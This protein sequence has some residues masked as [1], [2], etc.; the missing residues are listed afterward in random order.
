MAMCNCSLWHCTG[1]YAGPNVTAAG[2]CFRACAVSAAAAAL[3]KAHAEVTRLQEWQDVFK[4]M[5]DDKAQQVRQRVVE[6]ASSWNPQPAD[7]VGMPPCPHWLCT[8]SVAEP[9][10][11][12]RV[13]LGLQAAQELQAF[14]ARAAERQVA[15][16][17]RPAGSSIGGAACQCTAREPGGL[18]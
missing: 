18:M 6:R 8:R 15:A 17:G 12:L 5:A 2:P 9:L 3:E 1:A 11:R 13:L 10:L 16:A 7:P 14:K 4:R